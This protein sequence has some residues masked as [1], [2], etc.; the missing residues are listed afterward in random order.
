[1]CVKAWF[2][3]AQ[4]MHRFGCNYTRCAVLIHQTP[5]CSC[6]WRGCPPPNV[7]FFTDWKT[8]LGLTNGLAS[9]FTA[10]CLSL[11]IT[12]WQQQQKQHVVFV[13]WK[14]KQYSFRFMWHGSNQLCAQLSWE[15][16]WQDVTGSL[17]H[18]KGSWTLSLC[19]FQSMAVQNSSKI[20]DV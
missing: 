6:M 16:F 19:T 12:K 9:I 11:S 2:S 18:S 5:R 13:L 8:H 20:G 1:M 10:L 17:W 14:K 3:R 4:I 15:S 7:L